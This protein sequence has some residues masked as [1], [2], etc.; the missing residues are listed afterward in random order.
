MEPSRAALL[1]MSS[2]VSISV[3][4]IAM[5]AGVVV[6]KMAD[7]AWLELPRCPEARRM[8]KSLGYLYQQPHLI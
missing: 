2:P 7:G 4:A 5:V 8:P 3:S 1:R 6:G